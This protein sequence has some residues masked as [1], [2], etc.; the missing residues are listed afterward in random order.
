M[1]FD[2][3]VTGDQAVV[4]HFR[5]MPER[6][7]SA[8]RDAIYDDLIKLQRHVVTQKLASQV[9]N[10][11]TGTLAASIT[12]YMEFG[13]PDQVVGVLGANTPY[14]RILEYGGVVNHPGGTAYLPTAGGF[15]FISNKVAAELP[16]LPRTLPHAIPIREHS[17]MRSSLAD[18][19]S[20]IVDDLKRAALR[21]MKE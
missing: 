3:E 13:D 9:L 18:L 14:A 8:M 21:A 12:P 19:R 15:E 10:R 16:N 6:L 17:Y 4:A 11:K 7:R 2:S 5:T 20:T 1:I